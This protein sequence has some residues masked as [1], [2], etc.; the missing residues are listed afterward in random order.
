[1]KPI[2]FQ[3]KYGEGKPTKIYKCN[4][5]LDE[6]NEIVFDV[7]NYGYMTDVYYYRYKFSSVTKLCKSI[8]QDKWVFYRTSKETQR[9]IKEFI[10]AAEL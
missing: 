3:I 7:E 1:M 9:K 2:R 6:K 5:H 10:M 4:I 8:S